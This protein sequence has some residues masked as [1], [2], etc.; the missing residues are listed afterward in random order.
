MRSKV[1]VTV[2]VAAAVILCV[3]GVAI[4]QEKVSG[5]EWTQLVEQMGNKGAVNWTDGYVEAVGIGAPPTQSMGKPQARP[6]ALRAAQVDAYRNL[7]EVIN[8]VRVDSTTTIK[9]FVVASDVINTQVQGIVKGSNVMKQEYMSDGTV[10]VTVRMPLAGK[11]AAVIIPRSMDKNKKASPPP[12]PEAPPPAPALGGEVFTGL[13]VDARGIQ[14][15]PAMS[16]RIIDENGQEVYGSMIVEREYAVQQGMSGYARDLTAAQSNARVTNAPL[17]VKG[18]KTEG[19]GRSDIVIANADA[20]KIRS[21]G[22]NMSFLKKCRVM[23]VL[24]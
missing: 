20:A 8:G 13:V 15:R 23:I 12:P 6:M 9:D 7:L 10:E 21:A 22:D 2:A 18:L 1:W 19:A 14:A 11:F 3:A 16:P 24:D 17:S 4:G 5:S